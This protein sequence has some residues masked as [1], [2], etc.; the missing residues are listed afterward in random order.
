MKLSPGV[1]SLSPHIA[2][3]E[4]GLPFELVKVGHALA[5]PARPPLAGG[6]NCARAGQDGSTI[7]LPASSSCALRVTGSI[8]LPMPDADRRARI[9]FLPKRLPLPASFAL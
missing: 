2:L 4:A 8:N 7:Q 6:R 9:P 3:R 1:C 5:T